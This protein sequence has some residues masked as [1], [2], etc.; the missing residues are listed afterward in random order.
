MGAVRLEDA[1]IL[2]QGIHD[3]LARLVQRQ[4]GH[5]E[6][7]RLSAEAKSLT[8]IVLTGVSEGSGILECPVLEAS[9]FAGR[10][11]ASIAAFDL[12]SGIQEFQNTGAWPSYFPSVVRNRIGAAVA[13]VISGSSKV[14]FS[15]EEN[16]R[17]SSCSI[18]GDLRTAL[19]RPEEFAVSRPV[20]AVGEIFDINIKNRTFRMDTKLRKL[21]V[22]V[23]ESQLASVDEFRWKRV[24]VSGFPEDD[25]LSGLNRVG[26]LRL[27]GDE[28]ESGLR[29]PDE[30]NRACRTEAY[31]DV[32]ARGKAFLELKPGWNS[33]GAPA[34]EGHTIGFALAFLRDVLGVLLDYQAPLL[35]PF[36]T[37]TPRGGVQLEWH[38]DGRELEIEIQEPGRFEYL[39]VQGEHETEGHASRWEAVRLIRWVTTGEPK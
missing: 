35:T 29:L 27:A 39:A 2:A 16:G 32:A 6:R 19:Q 26:I 1:G 37:P 38:A 18:D 8:Q 5:S 20:E 3:A 23:E 25:R 11:P 10:P 33:Y 9:G 30:L 21:A 13:P 28:E 36:V 24:Y 14:V 4:L 22:T 17:S 7:T 31:K 15:I 12:I 34:I